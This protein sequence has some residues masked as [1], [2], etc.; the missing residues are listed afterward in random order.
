[1]T[2]G[3]K[4]R[5]LIGIDELDAN[6]KRM[7]QLIEL[8][9]K[10]AITSYTDPVNA[11]DNT[12]NLVR[13]AFERLTILRTIKRKKSSLK[14]YCHEIAI[15]LDTCKQSKNKSEDNCRIITGG[16]MSQRWYNELTSIL[17]NMTK[18]SIQT[19]NERESINTDVIKSVYK[20]VLNQNQKD[21][22][23]SQNN[24]CFTKLYDLA[25]LNLR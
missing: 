12:D 9:Y 24:K 4:Y 17:R 16:E 15:L 1:M 20:E 7:L 18:L 25:V 23:I 22:P 5:R 11:E 6:S 2:F 10:R 3:Q 14:S 13:I 21:M 19:K 8:Y